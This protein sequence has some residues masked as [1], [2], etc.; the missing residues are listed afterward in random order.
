MIPPNAPPSM[1]DPGQ[2]IMKKVI[3]DLSKQTSAQA[4]EAVQAGVPISQIIPQLMQMTGVQGS[5]GGGSGGPGGQPPPGGKKQDEAGM[6]EQNSAQPASLSA[7]QQ[8]AGLLQ[9]LLDANR[10]QQ[11]MAGQSQQMQAQAQPAQ[12]MGEYGQNGM[13]KK[14]F[15]G[16]LGVLKAI[17]PILAAPDLFAQ[18]YE[19][20]QLANEQA[21]QKLTG[22]EAIQPAQQLTAD[23]ELG[24]NRMSSILAQENKVSDDFN[25]ATEEYNTIL[26]RYASLKNII[27][28]PQKQYQNGISDLVAI[29]E[30]LKIIDP[31]SVN[32][33]GEVKTLSE[34]EA[35]FKR[36]G[37]AIGKGWRSG[38]KLTA[39]G[40]KQ[41]LQAMTNKYRELA[42]GAKS[43]YDL[44]SKKIKSYGGDP[45]RAL[46]FNMLEDDE[47]ST[48]SSGTIDLGD[49]FTMW[50]K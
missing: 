42:K 7:D 20:N 41:L 50:R 30:S 35:R 22:T 46:V 8:M 27:L 1:T 34:A 39:G 36:M 29:N 15:S 25:K 2:Q 16:P 4:L 28:D 6:S 31:K 47:K 21:R 26:P 14:P 48:Q 38:E 11:G 18:K 19:S 43:S 37:L 12:A 3:A 32:R 49:G 40:R 10:N 5:T 33:E 17:L 23:T 45:Q 9:E 44:H 13:Q 24:K